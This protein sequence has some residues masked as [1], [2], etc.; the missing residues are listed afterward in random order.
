VTQAQRIRDVLVERYP[1]KVLP[2]G[3]ARDITRELGAHPSAISRVMQREG[4]FVST[5]RNRKLCRRCAY[6]EE[7]TVWGNLCFQHYYVPVCCSGCD[8]I[9]YLTPG[10]VM[11]RL[12][13][14]FKSGPFCSRQCQGQW[15]G[16]NHGFGRE[17]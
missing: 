9:F 17:S 10:K 5:K 11:D 15:L 7:K 12:R 4:Y 2:M 3:A 8:I 1:S 16:K 14:D 6:C 13:R